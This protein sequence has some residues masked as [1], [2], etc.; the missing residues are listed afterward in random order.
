MPNLTFKF[1]VLIINYYKT[2]KSTKIHDMMKEEKSN[3]PPL[4]VK[5]FP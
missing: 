5:Q 1:E 3:I 4:N 2:N